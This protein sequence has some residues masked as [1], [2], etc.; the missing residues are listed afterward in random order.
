MTPPR[1]PAPTKRPTTAEAVPSGDPED[2]D[3]DSDG[4]DAA[5][6]VD[7]DVDWQRRV[8]GR[9]LRTA[10]QRSIDRG[11]ALIRAAGVVLER[12]EG[13]EITVQDVADEAGQSLRTLY[14]YF[15]SKD[16]LLLAVFEESM[17]TYAQLIRRAIAELTDPLERLAGA[18]VAASAMS[19]FSD[20]GFDRGL[21]R[22]RLRLADSSPELVGRSQE[23]L[24]SLVR[25]L[26]VA[27]ADA[28]QIEV[29]DPDGAAF[30][31]LSVNAAYITSERLGNDS[32]VAR[33]AESAVVVFC[34]RG[35]GADLDEDRLTSITAR[36]A[37]PTTN[38]KGRPVAQVGARSARR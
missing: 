28:G 38:R 2:G 32:G 4:D 7:L 24:T 19:R 20:V 31:V 15:A 37:L 5:A 14:Q 9:S 17:R 29:D 26:V 11:Q 21:A 35:L 12:S 22:L 33:P 3:V 27:A 23:A 8:V 1:D 36:L 34:L 16:D 10:T 18:V 6:G 30:L 13:G 25:E